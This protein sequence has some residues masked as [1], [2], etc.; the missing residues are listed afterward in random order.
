M[1]TP[2]AA[3]FLVASLAALAPGCS[4]GA[5]GTPDAGP[6][7]DVPRAMRMR[8]AAVLP[9]RPEVIATAQ[10]VEALAL[11]EGAG[12]RAIELHAL[13]AALH[14]RIWRVE[15]RDQD[16]QEALDLYRAAGKDLALRGGCEAAVRAATLAG[17]VARN[18][19]TSYAELY[20]VERRGSV[21][22]ADAGASLCGNVV[23]V[24][25]AAVAA[26][27]P[28]R[29]VLDAIDH[30]L[31][32]EGAIAL[33][34]LDGGASRVQVAPRITKIE[35]WGGA[36]AARIVVH[37]D[38]SWHYRV[39]DLGSRDGHGARTYVELDGVE[40]GSPTRETPVGGIV[41][42]IITEPTTTGSRVSLDLNGPAYRRVFQLLEPYRVVIDIAKN[43]PGSGSKGTSRTIERIVIDPGHGGNDPGASG[44][45]GLKE[46]DVTLAIAH[47]VAPVL[48]RQ[49][50]QVTLTRDDDRYVT[51][52]ERTARANAFGADLFVS[53]HCNATEKKERHGV[54]TYVLDTTTSD[55][56]G[57]VAARENATS[58]AASNEVA[59]LLASMRLAD[60]A[61]RSTRFAEL[62]QRAG[63]ASLST[64]YDGIQDGGVH[65]AAFYVLVGARMPAVLFETSYI[66]NATDE[67]RLGSGDYQQRL[68]DAI[69]N[70][71]KAY[72]EGR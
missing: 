69:A 57:R 7:G 35:Q 44:P 36:D 17:E 29:E 2:A 65:R 60:Q 53:I 22:A 54:E 41:S 52:E 30:G 42:R 10:S 49:G 37:L 8:D 13:A 16:A 68:A 31:A 3:F 39:G 27:R 9:A 33:A 38:R 43:P 19:E 51:L 58:T 24:P 5:A 48:A 67:Q 18:A 1:R 32:G 40:L 28:A 20:R 62:L 71:V 50:I 15:H 72:R 46:K 6:E 34:V 12:A 25:L 55:M 26:F 45:S 59:Q 66:S 64:Q 61:T 56:A 47:K 14:E 21:L 63:V 70:A 4:G 23:S 11:R